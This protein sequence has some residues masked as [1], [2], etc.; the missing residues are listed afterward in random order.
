[1]SARASKRAKFFD[2]DRERLRFIVGCMTDDELIRHELMNADRKR[3]SEV[4]ILKNID[5]KIDRF[6][7]AHNRLSMSTGARPMPALRPVPI[8]FDEIEEKQCAQ[9]V[10]CG[11]CGHVWIGFY[12][13]QVA[14]TLADVMECMSCPKCGAGHDRIRM[15]P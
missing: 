9:H 8:F 13:P 12:L 6:R 4:Q 2:R 5:R 3:P 11:N 15:R 14:G 1:M 10:A 7:R